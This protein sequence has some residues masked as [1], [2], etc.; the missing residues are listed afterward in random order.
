M[1]TTRSEKDRATLKK[2]VSN[3]LD[4]T[5]HPSHRI[6]DGVWSIRQEETIRQ[7]LLNNVYFVKKEECHETTSNLFCQQLCKGYIL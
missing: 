4:Q 1:K 7:G 3:G 5:L 6:K 2:T